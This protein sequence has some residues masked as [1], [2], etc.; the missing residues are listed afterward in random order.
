MS[1]LHL[2]EGVVT[3]K[4]LL[5]IA[6]RPNRY[7]SRDSMR[8]GKVDYES[9]RSF[10][11]DKKWMQDRIDQ[12]EWD[13]RMI[14]GKTPYA[15]I[16]YVRNRVGYDAFLKEYA[17]Y[18]NL[19]P[20][21]L[22]EVLEEIQER[23]RAFATIEEWFAHIHHYE[24]QLKENIR[25]KKQEGICLLT[26]HSAKGLE[27]DTVFLLGANEGSMPDKR[28][29]M[30]EETEEERRL[31]YVAMTRAKRQLI[32]SYV[33]EKNGKDCSPSRFVKELFL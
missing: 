1:Y 28:A 18:R 17:S 23:S 2:A 22:F 3:R 6:N 30:T 8:A 19:A 5:R 12:L 16:Q 20:A 4:D 9:L 14:A 32:I 33:K 29:V 31:F 26:M 13:M 27:Y 7:I 15:A 21:E 10:Y 11:N 25:N 24:E